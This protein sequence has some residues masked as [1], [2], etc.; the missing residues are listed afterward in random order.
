MVS[1][2]DPDFQAFVWALTQQESGGNYSATNPS[3]A[4]GAYQ[5]MNFNVSSWAVEATGNPVSASEFLANPRLQDQIAQYKLLQ[6]WNSHP[7]TAQVKVLA[8]AHDWN[9]DANPAT[10]GQKILGNFLKNPGKKFGVVNSASTPLPPGPYPKGELG[11]RIDY[12][13]NKVNPPL[14]ATERKNII[15]YM[16]DASVKNNL[17]PKE[18]WQSLAWYQ[19]Q[20]D[21]YLIVN[22]EGMITGNPKGDLG[23][24]KPGIGPIPNPLDFLKKMFD[25]LTD[26]KNWKRIGLGV[27]GAAILI[28]VI[29][30]YFKV[31]PTSIAG[32]AVP[33]V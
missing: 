33:V 20:D 19:K 25:W 32:K 8:T 16:Y 29:L 5:I 11:K 26:A 15:Q 30:K 4:L 1:Y 7:G 6:D 12:N 9:P 27:L 24:A 28:M 17:Q 21:R 3:G 31:S 23:I 13:T 14:T 2:A 10:Y 22:Y 18:N